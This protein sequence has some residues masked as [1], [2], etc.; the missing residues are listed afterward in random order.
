MG[1]GSETQARGGI[2]G[3]VAGAPICWGVCEVP[4]WGQQLD[5]GTVLRQMSE[6]GIVATEYGPDG[7]LP[8]RPQDK[9][10]TLARYGLEAV[11]QFVPVVLH[12]A[13][14]DP[15]P[16][17]E[18]AMTGLLAADATIVVV[19]AVTGSDGYDTRSELDDAQWATLLTNLD[20]ISSAA[21]ERGLV[22]TLHPHVGTVVESGEDTAR[23]LAGSRIR[24]C[25]DTGHLLIGGG[26]P[27]AVA[28]EHP[29]R[30]GH[31]HLKDVRRSL[32]EQVR[33][34]ALSYTEAVRAGM[35]VPL[36]AG[37][38]DIAAIV[39]SLETSGYTGWYVL[40]QDTV[41]PWPSAPD[42]APDTSGPVRDVQA[43][44][45]HLRRIAARIEGGSA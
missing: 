30:I 39:T 13:A 1:S 24:L 15:L 25:L 36:G 8:D 21:A 6:L 41:L 5:P 12:D 34:G 33:S 14:H 7:F 44:L 3:R 31:V 23:V 19:A 18:A 26:D 28:Q 42:T 10:G 11:G 29:D 17:V 45:A 16:E 4:G 43:S 2:L 38:V 35:Y 20:R 37:D 27:V 40:E 32:A 9:A 22:A